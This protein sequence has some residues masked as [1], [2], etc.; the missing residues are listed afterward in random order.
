MKSQEISLRLHYF[1]HWNGFTK[2][3]DKSPSL[4]IFSTEQGKDLT[5]QT[6]LQDWPCFEQD[7]GPDDP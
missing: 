7:L 1:K 3:P 5:N 2:E 4:E 6:Y